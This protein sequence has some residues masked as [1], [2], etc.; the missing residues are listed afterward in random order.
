MRDERNP[1]DPKNICPSGLDLHRLDS[2]AVRSIQRL[3][4]RG[5]DSYL[6]GGCVRDLL[7]DRD[8]KDFDIATEAR[9]QQ[10]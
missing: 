8:P 4:D 2:D 9:P 6:V 5:F 10:V 3:G 1:I 7:L